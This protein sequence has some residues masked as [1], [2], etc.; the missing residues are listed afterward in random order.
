[1]GAE[2]M[3]LLLLLL[4]VVVD[5]AVA[6]VFSAGDGGGRG[7]SGGGESL[8]ARRVG[9]REMVEVVVVRGRERRA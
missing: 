3:L 8:H 4:V 6:I 1:M 5:V 7:S 9:I 2:G